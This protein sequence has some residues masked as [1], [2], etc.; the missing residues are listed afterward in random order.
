MCADTASSSSHSARTR[1]VEFAEKSA[2]PWCGIKNEALALQRS[3][4][5]PVLLHPSDGF[6]LVELSLEFVLL[7]S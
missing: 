6:V 1:R 5:L 2:L 3:V 4:A 7:Q